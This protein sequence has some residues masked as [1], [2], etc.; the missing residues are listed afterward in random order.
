[1]NGGCEWC[2]NRNSEEAKEP[3][4]KGTTVKTLSSRRK[5]FCKSG[6]LVR[7]LR[8]ELGGSGVQVHSISVVA[9]C[10][11]SKSKQLSWQPVR[12]QDSHHT[13][14]PHLNVDNC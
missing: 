6:Y 7:K 12:I 1:M 14:L 11:V 4:V 2:E 3:N 9:V 5:K 13:I 8:Y 10:S